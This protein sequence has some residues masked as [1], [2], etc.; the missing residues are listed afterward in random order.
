MVAMNMPATLRLFGNENEVEVEVVTAFAVGVPE[1][2][3]DEA[4]VTLGFDFGSS[5]S[6]GDVGTAP[7]AVDG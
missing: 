6:G 2:R 1:V 5:S 7:T 4:K 3:F